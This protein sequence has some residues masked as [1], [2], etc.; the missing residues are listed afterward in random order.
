MCQSD[1]GLTYLIQ[2]V[3][4]VRDMGKTTWL[5]TGF[6]WD[7]FDHIQLNFHQALLKALI[8]GCDVVIDGPFIESQKDL[9][10][11]WKGSANQR[12]IDVKQTLKQG[13][14]VLYQKEKS[15]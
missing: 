10:L 11:V 1:A 8:T 12:V 14:V 4:A 13:H 2:L 15:I 7:D 6:L 3:N 5:W 9:S